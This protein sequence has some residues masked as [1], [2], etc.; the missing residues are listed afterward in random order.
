MCE[1]LSEEQKRGLLKIGWRCHVRLTSEDIAQLMDVVDDVLR[2]EDAGGLTQEKRDEYSLKAYR[3]MEFQLMG[4]QE[5]THYITFVYSYSQYFKKLIPLIDE[6][7]ICFYQG[8]YNAALTLLLVTLEKY[9]R[10]VSGWNLG[11]QDP[12]FR[13]LRDSVRILPIQE[14]AS[15]AHEI[16]SVIYSRFNSLSPTEFNFNRHGYL[17]GIVQISMFDEMNCARIYHLFDILCNA[18]G[19]EGGGEELEE[20]KIRHKIFEMS[21]SSGLGDLL[22]ST[23]EDRYRKL[24]S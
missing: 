20:Y 17:H 11:V 6:A 16:L 23:F 10:N 18:E 19:V 1:I 2:L 22:S 12:T 5:R 4:I 8:C 14:E 9:L 3:I 15:E 13:Q 24:E 7:T 21:S